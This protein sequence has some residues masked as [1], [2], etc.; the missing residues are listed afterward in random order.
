LIVIL[1]TTE[2]YTTLK[3]KADTRF[4]RVQMAAL[5]F[6]AVKGQTTLEEKN[7]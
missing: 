7:D 6:T 5:D 1:L 3:L 2:F 4:Y